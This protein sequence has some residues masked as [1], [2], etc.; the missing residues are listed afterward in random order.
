MEGV[1]LRKVG[2][3]VRQLACSALEEIVLY[4]NYSLITRM[5][6]HANFHFLLLLTGVINAFLFHRNLTQIVVL[7][8]NNYE[9]EDV[10]NDERN[11]ESNPLNFSEFL[12]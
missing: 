9:A 12:L 2:A 6:F 7:R 10:G 11:D 1:A 3:K 8:V 4:E 5:K